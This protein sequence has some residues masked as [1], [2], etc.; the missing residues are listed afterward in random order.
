MISYLHCLVFKEHCLPTGSLSALCVSQLLYSTSFSPFCQELFEIFFI[1]FL[2]HARLAFSPGAVLFRISATT[3]YILSETRNSVNT[4]FNF[5]SF[6]L[7]SLPNCSISAGQSMDL[8]FLQCRRSDSISNASFG[9]KLLY[10]IRAYMRL[11]FSSPYNM[12]SCP[13]G[14]FSHHI[15]LRPHK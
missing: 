10:Y 1:A 14:K 6:I 7:S 5:F 9:E 13:L 11:D 2:R 12:K 8:C 15:R 4:F 3:M